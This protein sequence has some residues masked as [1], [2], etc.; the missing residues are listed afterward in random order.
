[1][2]LQERVVIG[3]TKAGKEKT[4]LAYQVD[5]VVEAGSFKSFDDMGKFAERL[6]LGEQRVL[7]YFCHKEKT[8]N[9]EAK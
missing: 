9:K 2:E 4:A 6:F 1:M 5:H 3:Q 7:C 8:H